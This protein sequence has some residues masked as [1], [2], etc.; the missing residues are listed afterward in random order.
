MSDFLDAFND[1]KFKFHSNTLINAD[2]I[3]FLELYTKHK[4]PE[5]SVFMEILNKKQRAFYTDE[6]YATLSNM[7]NS[8]LKIREFIVINFKKTLNDPKYINTNS[9]ELTP[10]ST[11]CIK[12]N[13]NNNI[14][15]FNTQNII[16]VY[17]Y[18]LNNIDDHY[19]LFGELAQIKNPYTNLPFTLREHL[20][21]ADYLSTFY[22]KIKKTLPEY[23]YSFKRCYFNIQLYEKKYRIKLLYYSI[24]SYLENLNKKRFGNEFMNIIYSSTFMRKHCCRRCFKKIDIRKNFLDSVRLY[25]LNSNAIFSYGDYEDTFIKKCLLVGIKFGINHYKSHRRVV[26]VRPQRRSNQVISPIITDHPFSI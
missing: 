5:M 9:L 19:Y 18:G 3:I 20:I 15:R 21:L 22:F 23:L 16:K 12:L 14:Y 7:M 2:I 17:K 10:L 1:S 26:K 25:I 8:I 13:I 24:T 4:Y 11:E 6:M